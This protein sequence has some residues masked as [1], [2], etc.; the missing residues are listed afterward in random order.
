[1]EPRHAG[2]QGWRISG[3]QHIVDPFALGRIPGFHHNGKPSL[4]QG[5]CGLSEST[6]YV[7]VLAPVAIEGQ[8]HL[9]GLQGCEDW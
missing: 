2:L 3:S 9:H 8:E 5:L 4:Y 7:W 1:M 6:R